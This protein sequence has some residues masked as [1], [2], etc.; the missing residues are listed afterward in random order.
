MPASA[1]NGV[2][3]GAGYA[4]S[5]A[6]LASSLFPTVV[7][8]MAQRT[9]YAGDTVTLVAAA[10][11]GLPL[12]YQWR[13]N[14][15]NLVDGRRIRG[16]QTIALTIQSAQLGDAGLFSLV[17]S[18]AYGSVT[19][20]VVVLTVEY[21]PPL[22]A[23]QVAGPVTQTAATLNG[24]AVPSGS[25]AV[26]WFE[27]GTDASYGEVTAPVSVGS[28]WAGILVRLPVAGL[29]PGATYHYR[30]VVS[31]QCA[32]VRGMDACL[33]T[34][35]TGLKV[36][37]WGYSAGGNTKVP[38][39]LSNVVA[40]AGGHGHSM[41]LLANGT[42]S[43][44][45]DDYGRNTQTNVPASLSNVIAIGSGFSHCLAV[46]ADGFVAVWGKYYDGSVVTVPSNLSNVVAVAGGDYHSLA[47][48]ADGSV[49]AWGSGVAT[50]VPGNLSGIVAIAAGSHHNLALR[51]DGT[52]LTWGQGYGIPLWLSNV[53]A[54][55]SQ[56]YYDLALRS[57]GTVA[58]WG[59]NSSYGEAIV[60]VGLSNVVA[61]A[62]GYVQSIAL[63]VDGT[64]VVWGD[65]RY[66]QRNVP[67][68]LSN[69][70]AI[71]TGDQH[72]FALGPNIAP[73]S[74][75]L[76]IQG[77]MNQ[78]LVAPVSF[79]D[80]NGDLLT[81]RVASL[82][83]GGSLYQYTTN[84]RGAP[85]TAAGTLLTDSKARC[86]FAPLV[87]DFGAPYDSFSLVANDGEAD[88]PPG[89]VTVNIVPAPVIPVAGL[90]RGTNGSFQL[91]FPGLSNL[92][93][94]VWASTN[95]TGWTLLGSATQ[96]TPGQFCYTDATATNSPLRFYRVRS[97]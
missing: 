47:L 32:M 80:I 29:S 4:H 61:I 46:K 83:A 45:G 9:A 44:W 88:S 56:G 39:G 8:P 60:P 33:T 49:T 50:N 10:S 48:K 2:A 66:G 59:Y 40:I 71:A 68:G 58:A 91:S 78:D 13:C 15:T 70:T 94:S 7:L 89:L 84:G 14:G 19:S 34:R 93:Y 43:V 21:A 87:A 62:A 16:A 23:T 30:L 27:W 5:L 55:A 35:P 63:R 79:A 20:S 57:D 6:L 81:Y 11:G 64:V 17:V 3:I 25:A 1:T 73:T 77:G 38:P 42:V 52:V 74:S 41:A 28:G 18:N 67:P 72:C 97:P 54:V 92:T 53:L 82:P 90:G 31:N 37:P 24:L 86:I 69:V 85:I 65:N 95:L 75:A 51:A 22:A 76:T 96:T 26:A 12:Q 36:T